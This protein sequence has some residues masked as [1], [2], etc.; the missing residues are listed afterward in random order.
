MAIHTN[1]KLKLIERRKYEQDIKRSLVRS[2]PYGKQVH[3]LFTMEI[4]LTSE[5]G[6]KFIFFWT[7]SIRTFV[8]LGPLK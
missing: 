1:F 2:C 8:E 3:V 5:I 4:F 6:G 7:A